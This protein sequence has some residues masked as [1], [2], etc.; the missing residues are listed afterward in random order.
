MSFLKNLGAKPLEQTESP[1]INQQ[2]KELEATKAY[3][4]AVSKKVK[5]TVK[6]TTTL[7]RGTN[8]L[9]TGFEQWS[10]T[11]AANDSESHL[12]AC[13]GTVSNFEKYFADLL[14]TL[15]T[16]IDMKV[17]EPMLA[18]TK[19]EI[20][21]TISVKKKWDSARK[22]YDSAITKVLM[23]QK[24]KKPNPPKIQQAEQDRER[25]KT[26]YL[27]K[28][29]EAFCSLLDTNEMS[30]F[31]TLEKLLTYIESFYQFFRGGY[32]FLRDVHDNVVISHR[33]WIAEERSKYEQRKK[34][35]PAGEWVP[36]SISGGTAAKT[37][38]FGLP[39][40]DIIRRDNPASHIP[41]WIEKAIDFLETRALGIQG[42]FRVSPPKSQ[43]DET[44]KKIDAA[45]EIDWTQLDEHVCTGTIKLFLRELP[46]PL[47]TFELYSKFVSAADG[48][49]D[50]PK[51]KAIKSVVNELPKPNL[52]LL[53]RL[54]AL[55]VVIERNKEIN[56]MTSS[57]LAVVLCPSILYPEI[58]D[59]LTM[60]DDIQRAN[61]VMSLMITHF[62]EIFGSLVTGAKTVSFAS[63][64]DS[65]SSSSH[66]SPV[67]PSAQFHPATGTVGAGSPKKVGVPQ[68]HK[69]T[70]LATMTA[71]QVAP[72]VGSGGAATATAASASPSAP[73]KPES[74]PGVSN[75]PAL[76]KSGSSHSLPGGKSPSASPTSD[77]PLSAATLQH[78]ASHHQTPVATATAQPVAPAPTHAAPSASPAA[79]ASVAAFT[80]LGTVDSGARIDLSTMKTILSE[81]GIDSTF[82]YFI[83]LQ[84]LAEATSSFA[85]LVLTPGLSSEHVA[86]LNGALKNLAKAI[87]DI[88]AS[89]RDFANKLPP[90]LRNR[91]LMAAKDLQ[92]RV[93]SAAG[94]FREFSEGKVGAAGKL[95]EQTR[96]FV[97]AAIAIAARLKEFSLVDE[98][99]MACETIQNLV[100]S[101]PKAFAEDSTAVAV[102]TNS[103]QNASF[104]LTA[105][106]RSKILDSSN[107]KHIT[108]LAACIE[109]AE[110]ET[111]EICESI[112]AMLFDESIGPDDIVLS[113]ALSA[114]LATLSA[115]T[116]TAESFYEHL[117]PSQNPEVSNA[118]LFTPVLEQLNTNI[119]NHT[120]NPDATVQSIVSALRGM[121]EQM[122]M[123]KSILPDLHSKRTAWIEEHSKISQHLINIANETQKV[124][125]GTTDPTVTLTLQSYI[126]SVKSAAVTL[127]LVVAAEAFEV[128]TCTD[129]LPRSMSLIKDFVYV[130]FP[131]LF[132]IRDAILLIEEERN[133]QPQT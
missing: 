68:P 88:L 41:P 120:A 58:P 91:L 4:T 60:V 94:A 109:S 66:S 113:P 25:L 7:L 20:P 114:R 65:V 49:D 44:K 112:K 84:D 33:Q 85:T 75:N 97:V 56:K 62:T 24:E 87:K 55:M 80:P 3:L 72:S 39:Y 96:L 111:R 107:Q 103:L 116:K 118:I 23:L 54:L 42:V 35:R 122:N 2:T 16:S 63:S 18:F 34:K 101:F 15:G 30:E 119:T 82:D 104:K 90:E 92:D 10:T 43:L 110:R 8:D 47:L 59:P 52:A 77:S 1:P 67:I 74:E 12:G 50:G 22:E 121:G 51:I 29:E 11:I 133:E 127:S 45:Q 124:S 132:S 14:Q 46:Q 123:L 106:L 79:G 71:Q 31:E 19:D 108:E 131:V 125:A 100:D 129:S 89:I 57:N 48:E 37:R 70:S 102:N 21:A 95:V 81:K 93:L 61:R 76:N 64:S 40:E 130:S 36:D 78:P 115:T 98:L 53:K 17:T 9:A 117:R 38:M 99:L 86:P 128:Q 13:L 73:P 28:G 26:A 32:Q 69:T 126:K 83:S 27:Q 6:T 105:L 5:K